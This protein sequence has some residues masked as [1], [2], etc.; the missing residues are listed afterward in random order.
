MFTALF[1]AAAET[2]I[3]SEG[4]RGAN[5]DLSNVHSW[6]SAN[7]LNLNVAKT[8]YVLTGSRHDSLN[9]QPSI[10]IDKQ[11]VKRVK[12]AKVLGVQ[13]DEHLD[14][15]K[16]IELIASKILSGITALKKAKEF[17]DRNSLVLIYN[18]LVKPHF[19]YCC[20]VWEIL[21]KTV[22]VFQNCKTG[23]LE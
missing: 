11:P 2:Y 22:I 1:T 18:A 16:H 19:D 8:V 20:V 7:R 10:N 3:S 17:V 14:W 12:H 5:E 4:E 13:I 23:R 21:G 9:I 15:S 6:L